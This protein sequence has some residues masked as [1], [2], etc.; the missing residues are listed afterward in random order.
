MVS[1]VA[2]ASFL[3]TFAGVLA[4]TDIVAHLAAKSSPAD[5]VRW[6]DDPYSVVMLAEHPDG[7]AP[8]GYTVLTTPAE[9]GET[10]SGDIELRRIYTLDLSRG[11]GLGTML[12]AQAISDARALGANRMLLGVF[13]GNKRACTFYER[14]GFTVSEA[15][16]F[17]V[18]ATWHDDLVY[19]RSL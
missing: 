3:E 15:R 13:A 7:A 9:V 1:L 10:I 16:R 6:S 14:Q 18:G 2:G 19:A 11:T 4:A 5:F 8:V 12:M 17:K